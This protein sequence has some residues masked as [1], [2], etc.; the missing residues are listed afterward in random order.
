M[1]FEANSTDCHVVA[2]HPG[3]QRRGIGALLTKPGMEVAEQLRVPLYLEATD[4]AL[5]LYGNLGFGK[6][7]KGVVL[8]PEVVNGPESLE[9]P[10]MVKMPSSFGSVPFEQ[11]TQSKQDT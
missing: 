3:Y 5:K 1:V 8:S 11:W 4:R 10:I 7:S 6:L 2:V 9:A